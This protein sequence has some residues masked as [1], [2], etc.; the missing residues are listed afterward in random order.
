MPYRHLHFWLLGLFPLVFLAFLPGYFLAFRS[1]S[2]AFHIHGGTASA[3]IALLAFQSWSIQ[4]RRNALHRTAGM[5]SLVVFPLFFAGSLLILHSMAAK[6]ATGTDLF[7]VPH[8]SRLAAIDAVAVVAIGWFYWEGLRSR[9]N[10]QLHARW[11]AATVL[12]LLAPIFGRLI[13]IAVPGLMIRG[14]EDFHLFPTAVRIANLLV[15]AIALLL[16]Q[17]SAGYR[18]PML[19]AAGLVVLQ[20]LVFELAAGLAPWEA[21]L[22]AISRVPAPAMFSAGLAVGALLAWLGWA[23]VPPR[24][25]RALAG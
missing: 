14:P 15:L 1:S 20:M 4:R 16:A 17:R 12:F 5:A 18:R 13:G 19:A 23:A 24:P 22:V 6:F 25:A 7:Y 9:R 11:L 10:V 8:G 21:L 2:W 3:W